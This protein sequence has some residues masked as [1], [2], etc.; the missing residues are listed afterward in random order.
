MSLQ[1]YE[2]VVYDKKGNTHI[3][4]KF[5]EATKFSKKTLGKKAG[6]AG[7]AVPKGYFTKNKTM[8]SLFR[9]GERLVFH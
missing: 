5:G 4:T 6:I 8:A 1:K 7:F 9:T 2:Y 3:F